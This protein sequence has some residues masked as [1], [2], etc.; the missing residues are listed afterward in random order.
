MKEQAKNYFQS[1]CD[2]NKIKSL[3]KQK[4]SI[5]YVYRQKRNKNKGDINVFKKIRITRI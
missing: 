1:Q 2:S 4:N 3:Q 5:N